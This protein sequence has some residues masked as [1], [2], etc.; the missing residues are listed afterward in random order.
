MIA[1]AA[2]AFGMNARAAVLLPGGEGRTYRI[3][4]I[5]LRR[6]DDTEEANWIADLFNRIPENGFRVPR[7]V[8]T[9]DGGWLA[10]GG[11]SGWTFLEGHPVTRADAASLASATEMF[12]ATIAHEPA[13]PHL[14]RRNLPYD[15]SDRAAWG[16]LTLPVHEQLTAPLARLAAVCRPLPSLTAQIIHGDLNPENVLVA[17]GLPPAIIDIAPYWRPAGFALAIAAFW[18]GPYRG[19]AAVLDA[20][21]RVEHLDQLLVRACTRMLYSLQEVGH[22]DHLHRYSAAVDIVCRRAA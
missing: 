22:L 7:P 3:G 8:R 16:E 19:D 17:P 20:F 18:L 11:W 13:P 2:A 14:I 9:R 21:S 15:R 1:D 10:P 5:V 6:E 12:H 4:D